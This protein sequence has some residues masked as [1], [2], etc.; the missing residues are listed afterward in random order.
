MDATA[1][2]ITIA[3]LA[4]SSIHMICKTVSGFKNGP[5]VI[6]E[7][8]SN[9]RSLSNLLQQLMGYKDSLYLASDLP[10]LVGKCAESL[11][12]FEGKLDKLSPSKSSK[13]DRLWKIVKLTLQERDL[14]RMSTLLQQHIAMLSLHINV[15]EGF[16]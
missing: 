3:S 9:L 14:D 5:R 4:L 15:L 10:D 1:S 11:R 12:W 8:T 2:V 7:M 6:Q 16:V 13:V